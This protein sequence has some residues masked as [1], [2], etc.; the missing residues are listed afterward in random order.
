[1]IIGSVY[2]SDHMPP[3]TLPTDKTQS[4]VKSRS[5]KGGGAANF[6]E[7][8][9][10]DKKGEEL[11]YLH[12]EKDFELQVEHDQTDAVGNDRKT[13]IKGNDTETVNKDRK[14]TIDG[15][16]TLKVGKTLKITAGDA[17]TIKTGAAS[18][19]MKSDGSIDIKGSNI[20]IKG[21][22]VSIN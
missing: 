3:Y 11:F 16:D 20:T 13:T 1:M 2:N 21:S 4:G 7:L 10:E 15:A 5:T 19:S 17:I 22:K 18:I 12:A 8:R 14:N 6:N 9:F